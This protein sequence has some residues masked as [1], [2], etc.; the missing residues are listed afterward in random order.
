[1]ETRRNATCHKV[2][3]SLRAVALSVCGLFLAMLTMGTALSSGIFVTA[4]ALWALVYLAQDYFESKNAIGRL[5]L[6]AT[7]R[8]FC[9]KLVSKRTIH[10]NLI[11][12]PTA[13][14]CNCGWERAQ[15]DLGL[16]EFQAIDLDV[17]GDIQQAKVLKL[18][19]DREIDFTPPA[20]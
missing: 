11:R 10:G 16:D 3:K 14:S 6:F 20:A 15:R 18:E 9:K 8:D 17:E 7:H 19:R 5:K 4:T 1:M 13:E 12:L 2:V